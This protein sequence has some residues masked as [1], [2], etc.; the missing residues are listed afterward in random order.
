MKICRDFTK[1][2]MVFPLRGE[3]VCDACI[4]YRFVGERI[5]D[6]IDCAE[7]RNQLASAEVLQ[8][9]DPRQAGAGRGRRLEG[10]LNFLAVSPS[11]IVTIDVP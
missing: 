5:D 4:R 7:R 6:D 9:H 11:E 2:L 10:S 3:V 8:L 1:L